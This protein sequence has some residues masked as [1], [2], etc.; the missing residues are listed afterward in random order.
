[1]SDII[2]L[3][4]G[5]HAKVVVDAIRSASRLW[6]GEAEYEVTGVVGA[7]GAVSDSVLGVPVIGT[8]DDLP[9]LRAAGISFA[10]VG[11][12][13]VRDP[14]ARR[15]VHETALA[16]GFALPPIVHPSAVV[17]STAKLGDG[18]FIAAGAVIG[19]D[20]VIGEGAIVNTNA[21]CDH[22][23]LIGPFAHVAP[24]ASLSGSVVVGE[25]GHVGTGAAV[26]Q[27]VTI[28]PGAVIGVGAAVIRDVAAGETVVGVPARSMGDTGGAS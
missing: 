18:C 2:V 23:C 8:D 25:A 20:A 28:G 3:G 12:G 10:A 11:V 9:R 7:S 5:G 27:G 24:G 19:P 6:G 22:D 21:V 14:A 13:T 17:A 26:L 1:M 15:R 4:A 16:E